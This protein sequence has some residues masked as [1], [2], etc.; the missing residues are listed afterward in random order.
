MLLHYKNEVALKEILENKKDFNLMAVDVL[1]IQSF[2]RN[3]ENKEYILNS[4]FSLEL[5]TKIIE[6]NQNLLNMLNIPYEKLF[7]AK[8]EKEDKM[9][10]LGL[11]NFDYL[12][13]SKYSDNNND[14]DIKF[15][16]LFLVKK[17][18]IL[19]SKIK[20]FFEPIL[21]FNIFLKSKENFN[22]GILCNKGFLIYSKNLDR[23]FVNRQVLF[24]KDLKLI[25]SDV[26]D[27]NV[28]N[29]NSEK[30]K[31]IKRILKEDVNCKKSVL[32]KLMDEDKEL[33]KEFI[34]EN[35]FLGYQLFNLFSKDSSFKADKL[36]MKYFFNLLNEKYHHKIIEDFPYLNKNKINFS[37]FQ[38]DLIDFNSLDFMLNLDVILKSPDIPKII[39]S[40]IDANVK[41]IIEG[42]AQSYGYKL[43]KY[44]KSSK[45]CA[46]TLTK[47]ETSSEY[48]TKENF[49]QYFIKSLDLL[50]E[51]NEKLEKENLVEV[52]ESLI[53]KDRML[54]DVS[55][56][57]KL[58]PRNNIRKF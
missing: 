23:N 5:Y 19:D 6:N 47:E 8:N 57:S 32:I 58:Q 33:L 52:L 42:T 38:K 39:K 10:P 22:G 34:N 18:A 50:Y 24:N 1:F 3:L 21:D 28:L 44:M 12:R 36:K 26:N 14:D 20:N 31:L 4:G 37:K 11:V 2:F 16:L 35:D 29:S 55:V 48:L 17:E 13:G 27:F 9:F 41:T 25:I 56:A 51:K 54:S 30:I 45:I 53:L 40:D 15:Y 43:T 46:I 49:V 7:L